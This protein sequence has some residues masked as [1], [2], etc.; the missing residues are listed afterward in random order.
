MSH[1]FSL[2]ATCPHTGGRAGELV[3]SHG[4]VLTPAFMP[5]GSQ[6]T[7]KTLT[8]TELRE[9]ETAILLANNYHLYLRPGVEVIEKLGGLHRFMGWNGPILTDSGGYQV[10]SLSPLSKVDEEGVTFRSHID[11]SQHLFTP[12]KAIELQERLGADIIMALDQC[13]GYTEDEAAIRA[14]TE[15]THRWAERCLR[16]HRSAEQ[17]L[18]GI[19]QGGT[20]P[21]LRRNS[22]AVLTSM[23]FPGYAIGGLSVGERKEL[24]YSIVEETAACLPVDKPRY[25]M[26][27]GS[28]EDLVEAIA[29]G[30][31][32]FDCA[33]PTR[34]ARNGAFFTS[35]GRHNIRNAAYKEQDAPLDPACD[36]YTCRTFSAA[37][38]HHLF[39]CEEL[40]AYRL[41]TLHNLRFI[42]QLVQRAREAI[43][44][45]TF[46]SFRDD[47]RAT[48]RAVPEEVRLEQKR[49]RVIPGFPPARE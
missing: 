22:A 27:V 48:Y 16:S 41:T 34:V 3:T 13:P 38:V 31:D 10:F 1:Q 28:P 35:E 18:Y 19:V 24:T 33:L 42:L 39:K 5:V 21:A 25:L 30:V 46:Q 32:L 23:D 43:L 4:T 9:L 37:Y 47:F 8:P 20:F 40:L 14:A 36:C 6:A 29:R 15:R 11:G 45:N 49:K 12:E 2:T 17:A 26:G 7:V 44:G